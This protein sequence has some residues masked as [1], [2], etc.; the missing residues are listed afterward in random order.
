[1]T[2]E[3]RVLC[4]TYSEQHGWYDVDDDVAMVSE[5]ALIEE[6]ERLRRIATEAVDKL[7]RPKCGAC[8]GHGMHPMY[9][10]VGE[11]IYVAGR[12]CPVCG[13]TGRAT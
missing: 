6:C 9:N 12:D 8:H 1:M 13:G 11:L 2:A 5:V 4:W 3:R 10:R 7:T